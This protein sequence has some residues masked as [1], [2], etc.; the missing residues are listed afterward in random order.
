MFNLGLFIILFWIVCYPGWDLWFRHLAP[1][2][3]RHGYMSENKRAV[4]LSFDDGPN[5]ENTG[6][7]LDVLLEKGVRAT[8]FLV[9]ERAKA[10]PELVKRIVAEGHEIGVHTIKHR[11][12][13]FL[14]PKASFHS[15]AAGKRLLE[16]IVSSA[17]HWFRP[18]WGACSCFSYW[19][20]RRLGLQVVLW[21]AA[22]CDWKKRTKPEGV[23]RRVLAQVR[24]NMLLVLHD[25]GGET[26]AVQN[27]VKAL[28]DLIDKLREAGYCFV[29]L[30]E[31]AARKGHNHPK[32]TGIRK[33]I[34]AIDRVYLR[35]GGAAPIPGSKSG[36]LLLCFHAYKGKKPV[37]VGDQVIQPGDLVGEF[38]LANSKLTEIATEKS[39]RSLEWRLVEM[40][41]DELEQLAIACN[42]GVIDAKVKAFYGTSV[43]ATAA[44]RL[45]FTLIPVSGVWNRHWLRF[46]E[47]FLRRIYYSYGS[48]VKAKRLD[49]YEIWIDVRDSKL[50]TGS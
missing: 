3:L 34:A 20:A 12:A 40:L 21:S 2:I 28:P 23:V 43:L 33:I 15:L 22:A 45:G 9:G 44:R 26:G 36:L 25:A 46:W 8:F 10:Q 6:K 16:E 24:P 47:T 1:G 14:T 27:T 39:T 30:P 48:S 31:F 50:K 13:Y 29:T 4:H 5:G 49:P 11:H 19:A 32:P 37:T 7:V 35:R 18:P 41:R 38:H 42:Q 17:V